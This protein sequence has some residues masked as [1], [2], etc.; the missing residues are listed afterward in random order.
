MKR[1]YP[2]KDKEKLYEIQDQLQQETTVHGRRV[3]LL[4]M[5]GIYTGLRISDLV[6]LQVHHVRG[7]YI[8]IIEQKTGKEQSI[9]IAD[10][11]RRVFDDRLDG[12]EDSAWLFV[13]RKRN[14]DGTKKHIETREAE[15]DMHWIKARYNLNFAFCC[16]SMRK[17]YAYWRYKSGTPLET[18]RQYLNH[19]SERETRRYICIDEEERNKGMKELSFGFTP[20]KPMHKSKRK[21]IDTKPL[22]IERGDRTKQGKIWGEYMAGKAQK[23]NGHKKEKE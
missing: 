7:E 6:R 16:H 10:N 20:K 5:T 13:S 8:R 19:A 17:T 3:Y 2:I 11:L 21:G 15:Y 14:A 9:L 18:L 1:V 4:F 23:R 22:Y 12:M